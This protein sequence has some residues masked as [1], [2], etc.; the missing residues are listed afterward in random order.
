MEPRSPV[1]TRFLRERLRVGFL[2]LAVA[3]WVCWSRFGRVDHHKI[4][5]SRLKLSGQ[6]KDS[7]N[8]EVVGYGN[9][10]LTSTVI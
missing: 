9:N 5:P 6:Q 10:S 8:S 2:T 1:F 3:V 7:A 4:K